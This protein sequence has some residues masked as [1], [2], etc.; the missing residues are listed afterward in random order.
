ML[1]LRVRRYRCL[2]CRAVCT[3]VPRG[4]V[5]RRHFGA[6]AIG[7]ALFLYGHEHLTAHVVRDRVGGIGSRS[8]GHWVTLRRWL[9][10][11]AHGA[12]FVVRPSPVAFT[13]RQAAERAA[14]TL[15]SFAPPDAHGDSLSAQVFIGAESLAQ[16]A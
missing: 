16:A 5:R 4:V 14:M 15:A 11:V 1:V 12:L 9:R 7:W 10:A 6:G 8:A 13:V 3:V 2:R